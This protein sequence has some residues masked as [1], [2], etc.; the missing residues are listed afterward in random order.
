MGLE[1]LVQN[2]A[3]RAIGL[4]VSLAASTLGLGARADA[5]QVVPVVA[6]TAGAHG[7]QWASDLKLHNPYGEAVFFDLVYTPRGESKGEA[8]VRIPM[9][10]GPNQTLVIE[11]AYHHGFP[12]QSGAA[13]VDIEM[14]EN[15]DT[16]APYPDLIVDAAVFNNE[17]EGREY[18]Q[19]PTVFNTADLESAIGAYRMTIGKATERTNL[20]ITTGNQ[21][22]TVQ[23]DAYDPAGQKRD[24]T[25]IMD[26]PANSFTQ[27]YSDGIYPDGV[28]TLFRAE[29]LPNSALE[30][31]ILSGS[32]AISLT[33]NNNAS[34]DSRWKDFRNYEATST[35]PRIVGIDRDGDGIADWVDADE[36]NVLDGP[37]N[38]SCSAPF[39]WEG[40][41]IVSPPGDY[42]FFGSGL[43]QG[44][45]LLAGSGEVHYDP[46][47][48]DAGQMLSAGF[49]VNGM[50]SVM[51]TTWRVTD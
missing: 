42:T 40:T 14:A 28:T 7:S 24:D 32:A 34:N 20:A 49:Y 31:T 48:S 19:S 9:S 45:V 1:R 2:K 44:M 50:T 27:H 17:G 43:P 46:P 38:V 10:V 39:A 4:A 11:D 41:L 47:C 51:D 16:Q 36:D 22:A 37:Y 21:G 8:S 25:V 13:R 35:E 29:Q 18:G 23:W 3:A 12:S 6:A 15:P 26:Y 30:A 5:D 33:T